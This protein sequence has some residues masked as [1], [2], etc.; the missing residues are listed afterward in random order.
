MA[1]SLSKDLFVRDGST[2]ALPGTLLA[3]FFFVVF[4]TRLRLILELTLRK[5]FYQ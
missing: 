4:L 3:P 5:R 1:Y 2:R